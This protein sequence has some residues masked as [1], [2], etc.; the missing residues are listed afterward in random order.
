MAGRL[1]RGEVAVGRGWFRKGEAVAFGTEKPRSGLLRL[2]VAASAATL[3][4][5]K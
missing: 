4:P 3:Q 2:G 1:R 5:Q